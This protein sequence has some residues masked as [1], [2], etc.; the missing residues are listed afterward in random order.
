MGF[1]GFLLLLAAG[2]TIV[3][4]LEFGLKKWLRIEKVNLA[5]TEGKNI[6]HWGKGIILAAALCL[7]PFVIGGDRWQMLWFW[8]SY[9]SVLSLFEAFLQWKYARETKAYVLTLVLWPITLTALFTI[10]IWASSGG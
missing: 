9:L 2:L 10:A 7:L 8:V 5:E 6:N 4:A 1:G 3:L